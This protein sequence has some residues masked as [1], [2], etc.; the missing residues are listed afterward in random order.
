[1]N[2]CLARK[3]PVLVPIFMLAVYVIFLQQICWALEVP[4]LKGRVNDYAA[5]LSPATR[6]QLEQALA[7]FEAAESTQIVVLTIPSLQGES[8]E[9]F[10][11]QVAEQW[12]IGQKKLDNGAILLIAKNDRK[13]RIEVGYGLEGRLTDLVAGRII[14]DTIVPYFKAGD[15]DQ[16]VISGVQAM[17]AAV[18][19]EFEASKPA[20]Q[21][22]STNPPYSGLPIT[23]LVFIFFISQLGRRRPMVGTVAGGIL[24]PFLGAMFFSRAIWLLALIPIG[25]FSGFLLSRLAGVFAASQTTS[26]RRRHGGFWI[27]PGGGF[28]GFGGG[29]GG[30][31]GFS[32]GG[33]G[34]GGGGASGGW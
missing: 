32:G 21:P 12:R 6:S 28:G 24:L 17:M 19:G 34:F 16:G 9:T 1:M 27:G 2:H 22:R 13:V 30:F 7:A 15:F 5:I 3:K 14:R 20:R 18:K 10:S 11:M 8:I 23:L 29:G 31:G 25:L 4:A 33:G 26:A